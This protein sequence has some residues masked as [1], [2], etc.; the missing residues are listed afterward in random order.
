MHTHAVCNHVCNARTH[1][2][3]MSVAVSLLFREVLMLLMLVASWLYGELTGVWRVQRPHKQK[4]SFF[5]L[6][7]ATGN[8]THT[9]HDASMANASSYHSLRFATLILSEKSSSVARPTPDSQQTPLPPSN[10]FLTDL[11]KSHRSY[12][13]TKNG[14]F[15]RKATLLHACLLHQNSWP[16]DFKHTVDMK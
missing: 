2:H 7:G 12:I 16:S 14:E 3:S 10:V 5:F 9:D 6:R 11:H 15:R 1:T 4:R 8:N 13:W